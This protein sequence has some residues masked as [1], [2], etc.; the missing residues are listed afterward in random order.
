MQFDGNGKALRRYDARRE[1]YGD[2]ELSMVPLPEVL[3]QESA[4][5]YL[6]TGVTLTIG[7]GTSNSVRH[8]QL[9]TINTISSLK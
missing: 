4:G 6:A 3:I 7:V 8:V 9:L 1:R 5:D 2:A